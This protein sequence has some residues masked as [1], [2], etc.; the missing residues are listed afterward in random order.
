MSK[1]CLFYLNASF[2]NFPKIKKIKRLFS[3]RKT[4]PSI[5]EINYLLKASICLLTVISD[6]KKKNRKSWAVLKQYSY[7]NMQA[8]QLDIK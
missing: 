8:V 6:D 3:L 1:N 5:S 2:V 7:T 4:I